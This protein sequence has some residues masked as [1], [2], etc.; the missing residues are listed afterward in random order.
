MLLYQHEA[1]DPL[2]IFFSISHF[3]EGEGD[4]GD[5]WTVVCEGDFWG[6]DDTVMFKHVDTGKILVTSYIDNSTVQLNIK[7][8]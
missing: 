6:R 5:V 4:T 3:V 2:N 1:K 7:S 8:V